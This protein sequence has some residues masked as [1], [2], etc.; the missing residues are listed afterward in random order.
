MYAGENYEQVE[1]VV[2]CELAYDAAGF[3]VVVDAAGL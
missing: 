1:N 3:A 2:V